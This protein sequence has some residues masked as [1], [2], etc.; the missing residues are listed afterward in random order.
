MIP[1]SLK[2]IKECAF[3]NCHSMKNVTLS[4]STIIGDNCF[5]SNVKIVMN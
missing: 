1:S 4:S 3:F 2:E 5:P